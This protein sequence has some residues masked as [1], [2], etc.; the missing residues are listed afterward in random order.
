MTADQLDAFDAGLALGAVG[1]LAEFN[2]ARVLDAADVQVASRLGGL[3]GE[4]DPPVLLAAALAVR[5]LREGSVCVDISVAAA[6]APAD[7][8]DP[9]AVAALSW[10]GPEAWV[11]ALEASP[12]VAVGRDGAADRPLRLV[13]GLLYLDRY[14]RQEQVIAAAVD[15]AAGRA[16]PS[17]DEARLQAALARLFAQPE[18]DL[19][20]LAGVV[21]A[22]RWM[23]VIAGGPGT[24]KTTTVARVLALLQD[25][26]GGPLRVA[27]AAPTALAASRLEQTAAAEKAKLGDADRERLGT[28]RATTLHRLLGW[29]RGS[30]S[31]FRHDSGN[32]LPYDV[33]VVDEASMVPLTMM[34]RL[35]DA[36]RPTT[37]LILVGDPDQLASVEAGAV[38]G[39]LV[40]RASAGVTAWA[41]PGPD[42]DDTAAAD[43]P[44]IAAEVRTAAIRSG[45][46]S[47]QQ[48]HRFS[49]EIAALASAV[50]AENAS[51]ALEAMGRYPVELEF[52]DA[53]AVGGADLA[54]LRADVVGAGA[55]L[56]EAARAGRSDDALR[57]LGRHRLLC[58][59][60]EGPYGVARW[61]RQVEAW[62][63]T[64]IPGYAADGLWY[65][66]RPLLITANDYQARLYNGDTGV[67]V[68]VDGRA[69]AAFRREGKVVVLPTSRISDV[70]TL[71]AMSI[72][73]SQGSQFESV[74]IVLPTPDSPLLTREL[75]YT[76]I[77]RAERHV[78]IIGTADAVRVAIE[79]PIRRASGLRRR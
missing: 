28:L 55:A 31:R 62:L 50:K 17:V 19:Q 30:R 4:D 34:S 32:R 76:A 6:V 51:G 14:W 1:V 27:L 12:I 29:R 47:L 41:A 44:E 64:A 16:D 10:P 39:D 74:T 3:G 20:K 21:A 43:V 7:G 45:V 22:H 18:A 15:D 60:R 37:R 70:Q 61:G 48:V 67:V 35:V 5:A 40:A 69:R 53:D 73:K 38:L 58:A 42:L 68:A 59:H 24:G 54:S 46:V 49:D 71:H 52:V 36:L 8:A 23:S 75:F 72:H 33:V 77:T 25:Q 9:A 13:D 78:R 79:R 11:A 56:V 66:G 26:P 65:V 2:R 63:A 57:A